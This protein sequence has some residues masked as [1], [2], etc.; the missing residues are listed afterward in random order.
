MQQAPRYDAPGYQ[1]SGKLQGKTALIPGG[2]CGIGRPVAILFAREGANVAIFYLN[3][4][5]DAQQTR[6]LI[7]AE[8]QKSLAICGDIKDPA[9]CV[10]AVDKVVGQFGSLDILMNNAA[11]QEHAASLEDVTPKSI[12]ETFATNLFSYIHMTKAALPHLGAGASII[13]T[14]SV[15]W[16]GLR[17][18]RKSPRPLCSW[19]R[20]AARAT[21]PGWCCRSRAE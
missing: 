20:P 3:A 18:P 16:T 11:V 13:N 21:S 4:H 6:E 17:S 7:A 15:I 5:E 10:S 9:F 14:G 2:D 19:P 12:Q 8:A 1:G